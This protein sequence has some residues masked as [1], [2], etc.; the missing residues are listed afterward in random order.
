VLDVG[1][2]AGDVSLLAAKLVGEEGSVLGVDSNADALEL[3]QARAEASGLA[4][5]SFQAADIHELADT[6]QFDAI[7]GRLILEHVPEP[8]AVLR[9]LLSRLREGGLVAFQEYDVPRERGG[10]ARL[11][12]LVSAWT[13]TALKETR[14]KL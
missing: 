14:G 1:C 2:G 11:P 4:Q 10:V 5:V 13:R 12:A 7:V 6:R 3:A 8:A 9:R